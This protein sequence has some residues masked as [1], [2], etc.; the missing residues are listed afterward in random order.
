M[1][2]FTFNLFW[3]SHPCFLRCSSLDIYLEMQLLIDSLILLCGWGG[4]WATPFGYLGSLLSEFLE[5]TSSNIFALIS[6]PRFLNK[7][8]VK[9]LKYSCYLSFSKK[10]SRLYVSK[11]WYSLLSVSPESSYIRSV[12]FFLIEST[13]EF[14]IWFKVVC[15]FAFR[16]ER[17]MD[18]SKSQGK[19]SQCEIP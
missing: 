1:G 16:D 9:L 18:H 10:L 3:H 7:A 6:F 11:R 12:E 17:D 13:M 5:I 8:A 19:E 14:I 4:C 15:L 2:L